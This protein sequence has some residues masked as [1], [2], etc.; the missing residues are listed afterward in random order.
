[1]QHSAGRH[2]EQQRRCPVPA[3]VFKPAAPFALL[4]LLASPW[5]PAP[6][7]IFLSLATFLTCMSQQFHAWAHTKRSELPPIVDRLQARAVS[8]RKR[9]L[10]GQHRTHFFFALQCCLIVPEWFR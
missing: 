8:H 5:A 1:M 3:Q 10:S 7:D 6:V 4:C 9:S 2:S